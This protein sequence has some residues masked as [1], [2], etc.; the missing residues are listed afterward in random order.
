VILCRYAGLLALPAALFG[1][2]LV[3][4]LLSGAYAAMLVAGC[5]ASALHLAPP[6]RTATVPFAQVR[7][8]LA[9]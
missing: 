8:L 1:A 9:W 3:P 4:G 2:C 7:A 5:L 6:L